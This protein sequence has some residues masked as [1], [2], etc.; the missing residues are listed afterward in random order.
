MPIRLDLNNPVFQK[1]WFSLEK[2]E[3]LA[4]LSCCSELS[5]MDW[6]SIYRDMGLRRELIQSRTGPA[7]ERLYSI[8]ITQKVRAVVKRSGE[9]LEFLSLHPDHD[10]TYQ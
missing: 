3:R 10:S 7:N 5:A 6:N 1:N 2:D 4:V 9:L 8:R